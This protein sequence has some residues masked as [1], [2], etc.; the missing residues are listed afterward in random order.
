MISIGINIGNEIDGKGDIFSRPVL[1]IRRCNRDT[2]IGVPLTKTDK[3]LPWYVSC[4]ID[5]KNGACN[6]SQ[7]RLF[8]QKRLLRLVKK[9][10]DEDFNVI[11]QAIRDIFV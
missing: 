1:V 8:D 11:K 6:I 7:I 10:E 2:F 9:I 4:D 5:N 3:G